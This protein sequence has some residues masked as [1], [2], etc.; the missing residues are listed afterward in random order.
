MVL[1]ETMTGAWTQYRQGLVYAIQQ[2]NLDSAIVFLQ[3]MWAL[4]PEKDRHYMD[5]DGVQRTRLPDVPTAGELKEMAGSKLQV[6]KWK[7][8]SNAL[9]T[10]EGCISQWVHHNIDFSSRG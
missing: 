7:W 5:R 2:Q 9:I 1:I 6:R 10:I 3:G 8:V 4:L